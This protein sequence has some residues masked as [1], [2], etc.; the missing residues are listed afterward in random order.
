[1]D[2]LGARPP[3]LYWPAEEV[4]GITE[5]MSRIVQ[6]E[7]P[8]SGIELRFCRRNGER[9]AVLL[10][11]TPLKDKFENITGWVSS[12]S[13]ITERKRAEIRL[14]GEHAITRILANAPS[15]AEAA[16]GIVQVLLDSLELELGT[17]WAV[18]AKS[19]VLH[20]LVINSRSHGAG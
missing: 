6:G 3:F 9:F 14:A 19:Q 1:S 8:A 10:Q 20:P 12:V 13:D 7:T 15:P 16:P 2:L 4:D 18:D 11:V 17:F 5:A